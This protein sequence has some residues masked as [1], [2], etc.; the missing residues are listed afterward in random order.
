MFTKSDLTLK[1]K[2]TYEQNVLPQ[3]KNV[4]KSQSLSLISSL[5]KFFIAVTPVKR[6]DDNIGGFNGNIRDAPSRVQFFFFFFI[7]M[8]FWEKIGQK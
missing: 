5:S 8:Q 7:F 2:K 6:Q 3:C 4:G 1:V